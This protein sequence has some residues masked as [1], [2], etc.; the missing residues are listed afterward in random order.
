MSDATTVVDLFIHKLKRWTLSRCQG[1]D[2]TL[3]AE[4]ETTY[5]EPPTWWNYLKFTYGIS[6]KSAP[7]DVL[8]SLMFEYSVV[9]PENSA[10]MIRFIQ[11]LLKHVEMDDDARERFTIITEESIHEQKISQDF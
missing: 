10:S 11:L 2:D 7:S 1:V 4:I 5:R 3:L 8:F 6:E 9:N